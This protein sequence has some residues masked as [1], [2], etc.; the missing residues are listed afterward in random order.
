M[1]GRPV[2]ME[3]VPFESVTGRPRA[4]PASKSCTWPGGFEPVTATLNAKL[5]LVD[6][7]FELVTVMVVCVAFCVPPPPPPLLLPP[8]QPKGK[9]NTQSSDKPNPARRCFF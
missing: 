8:P 4:V 2:L 5:L 9:L 3:A 7:C 1:V 6:A